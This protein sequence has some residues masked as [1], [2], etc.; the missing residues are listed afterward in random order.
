MPK[1][2]SEIRRLKYICSRLDPLQ[3][4]TPQDIYRI[5]HDL[6]VT[7]LIFS[8]H[9]GVSKTTISEWERGVKMPSGSSMR[10]LQ[11]IQKYGLNI[12]YKSDYGNELC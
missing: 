9:L 8:K 5:R 2:R 11:I 10:L 3:K 12:C 7:Q 4:L 1:E 6:K